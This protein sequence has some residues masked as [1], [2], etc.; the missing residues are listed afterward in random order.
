MVLLI[1]WLFVVLSFFV[2]AIQL[3]ITIVE[4]KLIAL[5]GLV[6]VPFA[7]WNRTGF[8]AERSAA[9]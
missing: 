9:S 2:L 3:F 5:A 8:L 6:L 7:L 4:F 1:A